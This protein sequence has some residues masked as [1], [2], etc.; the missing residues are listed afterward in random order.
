MLALLEEAIALSDKITV[1]IDEERWDEV[2]TLQNTRETLFQQ[3]T[4]ME[5]PTDKDTLN[6]INKLTHSLNIGLASHI[7]KSKTEKSEV[8]EKI[9]KLNKSKKMLS[10]YSKT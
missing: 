3:L 9:I 1:A 2:E 7:N 6:K 8:L 4:V 5:L 10:A